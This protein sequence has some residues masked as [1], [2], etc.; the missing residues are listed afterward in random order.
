MLE[1]RELKAFK[2]KIRE[3]RADDKFDRKCRR[4]FL[5]YCDDDGDKR[6]S[7]DEWIECTDINGNS[8]NH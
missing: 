6:I 4:H 2:A 5:R 8:R 1:R 3:L 7:L